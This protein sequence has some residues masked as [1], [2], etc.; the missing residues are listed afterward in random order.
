MVKQLFYMEDKSIQ[1]C[2]NKTVSKIYSTMQSDTYILKQINKAR[3]MAPHIRRKKIRQYVW[4]VNYQCILKKKS[5]N[6]ITALLILLSDFY[7]KWVV[8][9][10]KCYWISCKYLFYVICV[11]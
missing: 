10:M 4:S 7:Y 6:C 11:I 8:I 5:Q 3:E 9:Y 1:I 2:I